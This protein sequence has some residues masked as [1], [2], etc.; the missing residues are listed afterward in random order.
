MNTEIRDLRIRFLEDFVCAGSS[1]LLISLAHLYPELWFVSFL[2]LIP[3]LWRATRVSPFE[4]VVLGALLATSYLFTTVP[5]ASLA[6]PGTFLSKLLALS[7][8]FSFYAIAVNRMAKHVGFN[9]VFI[10]VLWL[11][12]EY[13]LRNYTG[14]GS[15]FT[16]PA[17]DSTLLV[18]IGSL[19]GML[20]VSFLIVLI[21]SLILI[22]LKH[23]AQ[24][25]RSHATFQAKDPKRPYPPFTQILFQKRWYYFPDPRAPPLS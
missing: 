21:N 7:A 23:V 14:L 4:S 22:L 6:A 13:S 12:F 18:R 1:A 9:A 8:L 5:V 16:F 11:P 15:I 20:V 24:A 2:A 19:L 25:A 3:F 10:A 17:T